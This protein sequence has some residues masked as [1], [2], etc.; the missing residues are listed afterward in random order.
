MGQNVTA[1][2]NVYPYPAKFTPEGEFFS[3]EDPGTQEGA[4]IFLR[5]ASQN[6]RRMSLQGAPAGGKMVMY[7]LDMTII[8]RSMLPRTQDVGAANDAF[9][10]SLLFAIRASKTAGTSDGTIWQWGE[11]SQVGGQD[12]ELEVFYPRPLA[13]SQGVTQVNSNLKIQVHQ[14][15]DH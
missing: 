11:G 8:F 3:G 4:V 1:L 14:Y 6:E 13:A 2:S 15:A 10:D 7:S 9:L 5:V 12:I